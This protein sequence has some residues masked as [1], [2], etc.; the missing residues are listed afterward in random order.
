MPEA[1][2]G[3]RAEGGR[4]QR[5][6]VKVKD[7][8]SLGDRRGRLQIYA[9]IQKVGGNQGVLSPIGAPVDLQNGVFELLTTLGG[10]DGGNGER[11]SIV[12]FGLFYRLHN[13][14]Q[15]TQ[16]PTTSYTRPARD[17]G[18]A[19]VVVTRQDLIN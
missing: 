4:L 13:I 8:A 1:V 11:Y 7:Y 15:L 9:W 18:R 2:E 6:E 3:T 16:L 12:V 5:I 14:D 19:S 10:L 17:N